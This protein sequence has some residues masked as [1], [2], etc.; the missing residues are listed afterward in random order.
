AISLRAWPI[1]LV[2][3][4]MTGLLALA[5]GRW[6]R[7][8]R[9]TPR[10]A[11]EAAFLELVDVLKPLGHERAPNVTPSEFLDHVVADPGL[12]HAVV[13]A[14]ETIVRTFEQERFAPT[15]P[16]EADLAR[17]CDASDRVRGL[18]TRR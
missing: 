18:V 12:D 8:A 11:G 15:T 16:S 10:T 1:A 9:R 4:F 3:L 6:R 5:L 2:A 13:E 14:A 17:A 7:R